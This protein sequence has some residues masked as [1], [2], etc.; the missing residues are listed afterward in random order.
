VATELIREK[1]RLREELLTLHQR[2]GFKASRRYRM[3]ARE[4]VKN[5]PPATNEE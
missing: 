3:Y 4:R 1:G 2:R 5:R